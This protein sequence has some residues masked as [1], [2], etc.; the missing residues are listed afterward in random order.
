[1]TLCPTPSYRKRAY[2]KHV[3]LAHAATVYRLPMCG[4][5]KGGPGHHLKLPDL[6]PLS[7]KHMLPMEMDPVVIGQK[8]C[9]CNTDTMS[10]PRPLCRMMSMLLMAP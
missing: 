10:P 1:M 5:T 4:F 9:Q 6:P 3:L 8:R 2:S 7:L